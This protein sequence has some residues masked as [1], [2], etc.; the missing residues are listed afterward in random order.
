MRL[1]DTR[2]KGS[3]AGRISAVQGSAG[4]GGGGGRGERDGG[5]HEFDHLAWSPDGR[6][7]VRLRGV[8]GGMLYLYV[9]MGAPTLSSIDQSTPPFPK[10]NNKTT[11]HTTTGGGDGLPAPG[12]LRRAQGPGLRPAQ[13]HAGGCKYMCMQRCLLFFYM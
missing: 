7:L 1:W 3:E 8:G 6:Y 13:E 12:G 2:G 10:K 11:Q 4:G 9:C 5:G